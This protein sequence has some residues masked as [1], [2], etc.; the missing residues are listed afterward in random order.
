[1]LGLSDGADDGCALGYGDG[2]VGVV[3]GLGDDGVDELTRFG[4]G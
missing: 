1:M 4:G 2:V 3:D